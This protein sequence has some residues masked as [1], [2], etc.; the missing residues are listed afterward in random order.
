MVLKPASY[1]IEMS[2][3][4]FIIKKLDRALN[5]K[6]ESTF[7]FLFYGFFSLH[8]LQSIAVGGQPYPK[9]TFC[10]SLLGFAYSVHRLVG[11]EVV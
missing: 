4:R 7:L 9:T 2:A 8:F 5:L 10:P 11:I 1:G 6:Y 3:R